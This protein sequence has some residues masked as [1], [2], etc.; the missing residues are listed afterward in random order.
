MKKII[1]YPENELV[2]KVIPY[3]KP[4]KTPDWFKKIPQFNNEDTTLI[5]NDGNS[6]FSVKSCVPFLDS[7]L[8]GYTFDLW[9]DIQVKYENDHPILTWAHKVHELS[10]AVYRPDAKLPVQ[11]GFLPFIFSWISHWGIKTPKGYSSLFTHPLNRTDLPFTT[12]SGIIDTDNWGIWGRQPFSLKKD[13]EGII[14]AGTPL[15][16][17]IPFKRDNWKSEIDLSLTEWAFYED[18]KRSS[19]FK[20]YYKSKYWT[21]KV[22][23]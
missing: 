7:F 16:Q 10:P 15:I 5:V 6:N 3:P 2:Q 20:G 19:K 17:V 9:C 14:P 11:D 18:I 13:W 4:V 22:F 1:F 23:N 21:K 12:T 8:T